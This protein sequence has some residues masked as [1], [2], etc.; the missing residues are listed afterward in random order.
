MPQHRQREAAAQILP[1]AHAYSERYLRTSVMR[2]P[3]R[4]VMVSP[5]RVPGAEVIDH[6]A[7]TTTTTTTA[8][9]ASA[10]NGRTGDHLPSPTLAAWGI[11]VLSGAATAANRAA[12]RASSQGNSAATAD[13]IGIA[14]SQNKA[15]GF[16]LYLKKIASTTFTHIFLRNKGAVR[17]KYKTIVNT[18]LNNVPRRWEEAGTEAWTRLRVAQTPQGPEGTALPLPR[19]ARQLAN[20][21]TRTRSKLT[22]DWLDKT[23]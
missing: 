4:L 16:E 19:T 13:V 15:I 12:A 8:P 10:S 18:F 20:Q 3:R 6:T 14:L 9:A 1:K 21:I 2:W 22:V 5:S 7:A 11:I 17:A 23:K